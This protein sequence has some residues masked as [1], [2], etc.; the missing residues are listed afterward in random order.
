[1][2]LLRSFIT[3]FP[4]S[5]LLIASEP[6]E[7]LSGRISNVLPSIVKIKVQRSDNGGDESELITDS[8]GGTGFVYDNKRHVLTNAHVIGDAKKIAIVDLNGTEYSA[9][10]I[11]KDEKTD[12]AVI[13]VP[14]INLPMLQRGNSND[15][16]IGDGLLAIGYPFSLGHSVSLGIVGGLHRFL[17]NYP[18]VHFIQTDAAVNPGNSGGPLL[19]LTGE[20]VGMVSTYFSR[21]GGYTNIAF[22][23]P[24]NDTVRIAEHLIREGKIER[25]YFGAEL[26]ISEKVVR[27]MGEK[28]GVLVTRI[29]PTSPA[30]EA[31]IQPGDLIVGAN[32]IAFQDNGELHRVLERSRSGDTIALTLMRD[33]RITAAEVTLGIPV[34]K[35]E[36][37]TNIATS[38]QSEKLGLVLRENDHTLK[39][40]ICY[41]AA[42]LAG[43]QPNDTIRKINGKPITT[44]KEL[45]TYLAKLKENDLTLLHVERE[46]ATFT[47]PIGTKSAIK[48]YGSKN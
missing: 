22:A 41:D 26:L 5:A 11:G 24:I 17:P 30:S 36:A 40:I 3:I 28:T 18:Y 43:F 31:G 47:L 34:D 29:D 20:A 15:L 35:K 25:G 10:L 44:I 27:K 39:V 13:H 37:V 1:M 32:G 16:K 46:G 45:N 33:R 38:D 2:I 42:K 4:L 7:S 12:I 23:I 9:I 8:S 21:Q 14:G 19:N 48:G 6:F